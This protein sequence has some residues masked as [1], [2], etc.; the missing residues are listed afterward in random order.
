MA[1]FDFLSGLRTELQN[2]AAQLSGIRLEIEKNQCEIE[3]VEFAPA[4]HSDV[5]AALKVWAQGQEAR[6]KTHLKPQ[7]T[8]LSSKPGILHDP[9]AVATEFAFGAFLQEPQ[10]AR[11]SLDAQLCGLLGADRF[12]DLM[13]EKLAQLD[14]AQSGLALADRRK[15]VAALKTKQE[16]LRKKEREL[17]DAAERAG[18][19]VS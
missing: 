6:Y 3:D 10:A 8:R 2:F 15:Q 18:L 1:L 19:S 14:M 7:L 9:A 13:A 17:L 16:T 4:A 5:L 12:T 11:M